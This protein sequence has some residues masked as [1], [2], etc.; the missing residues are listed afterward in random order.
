MTTQK[1]LTI[2]NRIILRIAIAFLLL[3]THVHTAS[4]SY[5]SYGTPDRN[6]GYHTSYYSYVSDGSPVTSITVNQAPS[7]SAYLTGLVVNGHTSGTS[8]D[9]ENLSPCPNY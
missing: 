2:H 3:V 7:G 4:W 8:I 5:F 1:I 6:G 9:S